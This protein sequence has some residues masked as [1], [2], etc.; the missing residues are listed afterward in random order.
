M[1]DNYINLLTDFDNAISKNQATQINTFVDSALEF[2]KKHNIF[3]RSNK[4][5]VFE[6]DIFDCLPLI[7]N[8]DEKDKILDLGSGG[9]FPG[10]LI[11]ILKPQAQTRL[12]EKNQKKC[13]FLNKMKDLLSLTNTKIIKTTLNN[14]NNLGQFSLI[15]ARAFSST[16]NILK[17]TANNL[18]KGGRYTLLKGKKEKILE[19]IKSLNTNKYKYEIIKIENKNSERHFL[20]I[21]VNE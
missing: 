18:S 8:I 19:E 7:K 20:Q 10:I 14:K 13:Y 6:K 9:G 11:G 5:E 1:H 21:R 3:V 16:D 17:L 2:N 15:T 4:E 12:L